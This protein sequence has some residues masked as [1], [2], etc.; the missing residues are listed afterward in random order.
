MQTQF[1]KISWEAD[2]DAK[3]VHAPLVA[4]CVFRG[5]ARPATAARQHLSLL[6]RLIGVTGD[7]GLPSDCLVGRLSV[8]PRRRLALC[9]VPPAGET[10]T[11]IGS[12]LAIGQ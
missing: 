12:T 1:S 9:F 5:A 8:K 3:T 7:D 4:G 6:L 2:R 11:A 10:S